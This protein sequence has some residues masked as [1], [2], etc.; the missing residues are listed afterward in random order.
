MTVEPDAL[1]LFQSNPL[2]A[3]FD[4][5]TLPAPAHGYKGHDQHGFMD[6]PIEERIEDTLVM[7]RDLMVLALHADAFILTASSNVG[8]VGL[9]M[10]GPER[11]I[12]S[13]DQRFLPLTRVSAL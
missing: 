6:W 9:M 1:E 4:I 2:G 11:L 10:G 7:M 5:R 13:T 8:V 12:R 3:Q